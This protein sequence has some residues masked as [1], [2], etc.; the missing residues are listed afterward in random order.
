MND[1]EEKSEVI[2]LHATEVKKQNTMFFDP[3]YTT[4]ERKD[5]LGGGIWEELIRFSDVKSRIKK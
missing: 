2:G 5:A 3:V 1:N 4:C